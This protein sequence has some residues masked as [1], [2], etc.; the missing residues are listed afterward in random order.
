MT[1][2]DDL[3]RFVVDVLDSEENRGWM[4]DYKARWKDKL[5]QLEVWVVSF[6]IEIG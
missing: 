1:Y 3:V 5:E 2:R 4:R 6:G